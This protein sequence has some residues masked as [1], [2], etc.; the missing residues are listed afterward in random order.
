MK[1]NDFLVPPKRYRAERQ[2][3]GRKP[4]L[5]VHARN[6][7]KFIIPGLGC[8]CLDEVRQKPSAWLEFSNKPY[9][10]SVLGSGSPE[11]YERLFQEANL[12]IPA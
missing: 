1:E 7:I 2:P 11:K 8:A 3:E 12:G 10:Y 6:T 9:P 5:K 4:G